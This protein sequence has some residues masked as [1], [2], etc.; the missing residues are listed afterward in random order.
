MLGDVKIA[1]EL[2][3]KAKGMKIRTDEANLTKFF[4]ALGHTRPE[5]KASTQVQSGETT[6]RAKTIS[7][8]ILSTSDREVPAVSEMMISESRVKKIT[9]KNS[10]KRIKS[11]RIKGR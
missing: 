2:E 6:D 3:K 7:G 4:Q 8:A 9:A 5:Q 11:S 10:E 1:L